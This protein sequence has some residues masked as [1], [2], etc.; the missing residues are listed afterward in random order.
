VILQFHTA[1]VS[2]AFW[3][4][5]RC[6]LGAEAAWGKRWKT[7]G[8]F[9]LPTEPRLATRTPLN[10]TYNESIRRMRRVAW[11]RSRSAV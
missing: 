4:T 8:A 3:A 9:L 11:R 7:L 2:E 1:F 6:C 10:D 5:L